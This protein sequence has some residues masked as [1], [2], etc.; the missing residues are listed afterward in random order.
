M[1]IDD[2]NIVCM[3][4]NVA[5]HNIWLTRRLLSSAIR[6]IDLFEFLLALFDLE[7]SL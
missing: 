6:F 3:A 5:G 1:V 7:V 2:L 4:A